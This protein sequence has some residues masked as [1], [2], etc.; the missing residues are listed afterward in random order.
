MNSSQAAKNAVFADTLTE[1]LK[2]QARGVGADL[3]GIASVD[4]FQDAPP[5]THPAGILPGA[6]SVVVIAVKYPDATIDQW[7]KPPAES[8]FFY[9]SVQNYMTSVVMPMIQ[10]HVYRALERAGYLA[11]PVAPSGYWRYRDYQE[12]QGGFIAD[13]S[14]R[15][16]AV[17][18]GLGELGLNGLLLTP[19]FGIRQRMASV[20]TTAPLRPDEPYCGKPLCNNCGRCLHMCPV[21]AFDANER[22]TARIGDKQLTYA[23]VDKWKCAWSE[24]IGMVGEGGP[25]YAGYTTNVLPPAHVTPE[26]Y[27][28]ARAQRDPFQAT[29]EWGAISCGRCLHAC[30]AHKRSTVTLSANA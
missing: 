29:C 7:G 4:V 25:K 18:A 20:I 19:E 5:R 11:I 21:Q 2:T 22:L 10:F 9:Q 14:H 30:N 15:H 6:K 24:Q 17:A 12:M 16:A 3:V 8:M 26:A 28:A 27:L 13:F 23:K 1:D